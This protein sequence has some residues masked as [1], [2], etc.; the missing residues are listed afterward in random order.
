V[1]PVLRQFH[2][3]V[4]MPPK[5]Y[6]DPFDRVDRIFEWFASAQGAFGPTRMINGNG[7]LDKWQKTDTEGAHGVAIFEI[8]DIPIDN[9]DTKHV[10]KYPIVQ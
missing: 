10:R 3:N 4:G 7:R 5:I 8:P 6:L 9:L 2:R 1:E